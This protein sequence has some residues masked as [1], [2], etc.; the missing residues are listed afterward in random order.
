MKAL[1]LAFLCLPAFAQVAS[2][3]VTQE[4]VATTI[5]VKGYTATVRPPVSY[6]RKVKRSL[7]KAR[8][9]P[10]ANARL[11]ELDHII[12]L[13]AGGHP[14][15]PKNLQLQLW[16]GPRNAHIKDHLENAYHRAICDGT[17]TLAI[18]Q[19]YFAGIW[20]LP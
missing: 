20:V 11:Y 9:I 17:V 5:C 14:T 1:A 10:L 6:T 2:P 18:A 12:P 8:G 7:L 4:N 13:E 3:A 19:G 16:A 15:D